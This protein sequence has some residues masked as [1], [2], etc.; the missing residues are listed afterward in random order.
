MGAVKRMQPSALHNS[1]IWQESQGYQLARGGGDPPCFL[2]QKLDNNLS[3]LLDSA[4]K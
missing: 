4:R 1:M 3:G 2:T